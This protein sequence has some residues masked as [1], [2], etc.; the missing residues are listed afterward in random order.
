MNKAISRDVL[1]A[2]FLLVVCGVLWV[3]SFD[4]RTPDYGQLSPATWPRIIIGVM[5]FLSLIFFVQ[6]VREAKRSAS[7]FQSDAALPDTAAASE[8]A[9]P[10][11]SVSETNTN[12]NPQAQLPGIAGFYGYWKNVIWCFVLFGLYLW[13][14]PYLGMLVAAMLFV[15]LLLCALGGW[16]P[17]QILFHALIALG[18]VG[19]MWSL[20]TFGLDV[21]LPGGELFSS[22]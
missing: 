9:I 21:I 16:Q 3:A 13:S 15:F 8:T 11:V 20:F 2:V 6:S 17:K 22:R 1:V 4:I 19:G 5:T 14:M 18:T 7:G 12:E 10:E